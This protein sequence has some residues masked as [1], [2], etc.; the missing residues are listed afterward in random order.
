M[1]LVTCCTAFLI[2]AAFLLWSSRQRRSRWWWSGV[3][4][5]FTAGAGI[6]YGLAT[7]IVAQKALALLMMPAGLTWLLLI[8][9]TI[10]AWHQAH[11]ALAIL[12]SVTL[13]LYTVAGNAWIGDAVIA[14]LEHR[15]PSF[16]LPNL[17]PFDAI[18]VLGG[19][20]EFNAADG[21]L[22]GTAGDRIALAARLWHAGK[23]RMLVTS[24]NSLSDMEEA[25]D[26]AAE[27]ALL[28]RGLAVPDSA[29]VAV[30][31]AAVNT[32][33]EIA[34]YATLIRAR[35]WTRVGLL[36]SAWHLPRALRLARTQGLTMV[37]LGADRRGRFRGWSP[38][39]LIPQDHGFDRVQRACW[40]YLGMLKGR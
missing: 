31:T 5:A 34:A 13:G 10:V 15:I 23:T 37:P 28:W 38:Y 33:Q 29:I 25:R 7:D 21:P 39:W 4:A 6:A 22:L 35:G 30:P 2:A 16:D 19:G 17:Q 36:S 27:T 24:G 40:E 3:L 12:A 1:I 14:S 8:A 18:F 11:R 20:S 9:V 32:T 26:L